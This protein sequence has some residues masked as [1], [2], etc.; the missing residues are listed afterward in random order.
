MIDNPMLDEFV[1][2][3]KGTWKAIKGKCKSFVSNALDVL[4]HV[5]LSKLAKTFG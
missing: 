5:L 3:L 4:F 2:A 1:K